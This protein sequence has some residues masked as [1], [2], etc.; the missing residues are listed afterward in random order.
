MTTV[1][2]SLSVDKRLRRVNKRQT[3][4]SDV[5]AKKLRRSSDAELRSGFLT[6]KTSELRAHVVAMYASTAKEHLA[7]L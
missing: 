3:R 2:E 7:S 6:Q 1:L 4:S 5:V